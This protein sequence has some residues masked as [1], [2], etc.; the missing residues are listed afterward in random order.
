MNTLLK[1][2]RSSLLAATA[3]VLMTLG[4]CASYQPTPTAKIQAAELAI[5]A[6]EIAGVNNYASVELTEARRNLAAANTAVLKDEMT[7]ALH[8]A[9]QAK[10]GAE[11]A[12][13]KAEVTAAQKVNDDMINSIAALKTEM[14][15]NRGIK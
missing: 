7:I 14:Q 3:V 8:L 1:L 9:E 12:A 2:Q 5:K 6:A 15:R 10:I 13:A 4:A 11:L